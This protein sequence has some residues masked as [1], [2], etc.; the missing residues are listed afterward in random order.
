MLSLEQFIRMVGSAAEG[1][2]DE[3]L[4]ERRDHMDRLLDLHFEIWLEQRNHRDR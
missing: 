3:E 2:T 4:I 1:L